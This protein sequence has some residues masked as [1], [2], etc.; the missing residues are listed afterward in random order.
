VDSWNSLPSDL[1]TLL[2]MFSWAALTD[3]WPVIAAV[4]GL[5][6]IFGLVR[7]FVR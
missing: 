1:D 5:S 2:G 3:L 4:A 7:F 6:I